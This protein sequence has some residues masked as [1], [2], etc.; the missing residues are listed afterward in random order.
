MSYLAKLARPVC[1]KGSP[2]E[3]SWGR[4]RPIFRAARYAPPFARAM[5]RHELLRASDADRD[6]VIDRPPEAAREG[7]LESDELEQR[8]DG[9]L[10]ARTYG[11]LEESLAD[12]PADGRVL[13]RRAGSRTNS[14]AR[15]APLAAG[16]PGRRDPGL[17]LG[18]LQS[19]CWCSQRRRGGSASFSSGTFAAARGGASSRARLE[20]RASWPWSRSAMRQPRRSRRP[21]SGGAVV[22]RL[23]ARSTRLPARPSSGL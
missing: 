14:V 11:Q 4:R 20:G 10:H 18:R 1:E 15:S 16:L 8:V 17:R 3:H 22:H 13:W 6:A 21:V 9:A 23:F 19:R 5:R 12:L 2:N 7:R